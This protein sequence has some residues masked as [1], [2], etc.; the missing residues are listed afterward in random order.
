LTDYAARLPKNTMRLFVLVSIF[1]FII[2][3][4]C[5][6][7]TKEPT[8]GTPDSHFEVAERASLE[9]PCKVANLGQ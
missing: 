2:A 7:E 6:E 8:F 9:L 4:S 1:L 3:L 5:A